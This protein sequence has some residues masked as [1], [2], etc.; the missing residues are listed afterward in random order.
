M[1]TLMM[2]IFI[3]RLWKKQIAIASSIKSGIVKS[4]A[5]AVFI[6]LVGLSTNAQIR[7]FNYNITISGKPAGEL[8]LVHRILADSQVIDI[9]MAIFTR[10]IFMFRV[11]A[12]EKTIFQNGRLRYTH[13][14]RQI[15]KGKK[16]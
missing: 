8:N 5:L 14:S 11:T 9:K 2:I 1:L 13:I 3:R 4:S 10:F 16:P 12:V 15:N 6:L 7:K